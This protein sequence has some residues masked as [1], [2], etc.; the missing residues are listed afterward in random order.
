MVS[1]G[2]EDCGSSVEVT[3]MGPTA[4]KARSRLRFHWK[5]AADWGLYIFLVYAI[6]NSEVRNAIQRMKE[7]KKALSFT[8]NCSQQTNYLSSPK[9]TV[10][11]AGKQ[12]ITPP[13][14]NLSEPFTIKKAI[15]KGTIIT[16]HPVHITSILS[17]D[18]TDVELT[19][20]KTSVF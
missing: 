1:S 7:K 10:W 2:L 3:D 20:F 15:G 16:N 4:R 19:A 11:D 12:S 18:K 5:V 9:S 6:Y 8:D 13:S 14:S 17:S